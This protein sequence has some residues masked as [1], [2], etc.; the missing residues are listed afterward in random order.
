MV[1]QRKGF[2]LVELLAATAIVGVLAAT[3]YPAFGRARESARKGL[4]L[5]NVKIVAQGIQMYLADNDDTLPPYESRR[6]VHDWW[7]ANAPF[8]SDGCVESATYANPYLRWP[9]I[10]DEYVKNR[11]VWR[12]PSARLES[13]V[14]NISPAPEPDWFS[15]IVAN[16]PSLMSHQSHTEGLCPFVG[17][18]PRGWGGAI[19]DSFRQGQ[20]FDDPRAFRLSIGCNAGILSPELRGRYRIMGLKTTTVK[21]PASFVICGDA[22]KRACIDKMNLPLAAYPDICRL[23]CSIQCGGR[24]TLGPDYAPADGSMLAYPHLRKPYARHLEGVNLGFLDGH[25]AWWNSERLIAEFAARSRAG[26]PYPLGLIMPGLASFDGPG[27]VPGHR[28]RR[29]CSPD[30]PT[31]F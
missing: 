24:E 15:A 1:Q 7:A 13:V 4:C 31:L 6:D 29:R 3:V 17:W 10:L 12:C 8:W 26:D 11:E 14:R 5:S 23:S 16:G 2:T 27:I 25:V 22:G 30:T 18:W 28:G 20:A 9:V 21:D 19:T